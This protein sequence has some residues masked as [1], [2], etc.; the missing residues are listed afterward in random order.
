M[1]DH[2]RISKA[3]RTFEKG[4]L[5]NLTT[6]LFTIF[7]KV[8]G[9][10]AYRI[11]DD[12]GEELEGTFYAKELQQVVKTDDVYEVEAVVAYKKRRVGK[13]IFP[14]VKVRWKGYPPSLDSWIPQVDLILPTASNGHS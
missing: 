3:K 4:Y 5:P 1:D 11:K 6:E 7:R 13:K 2:V 9:R 12:H 14:E 8:P 10:N